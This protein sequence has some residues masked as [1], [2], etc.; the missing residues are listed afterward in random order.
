MEK[1]QLDSYDQIKNMLNTMRK[2]NT[3]NYSS[4]REQISTPQQTPTQQTQPTQQ[5]PSNQGGKS[6]VN[7]I[8]NVEVS[9]NSND[10]AD[11]T[12]NDDQKGNISQLIDDFRSEV[13]ELTDFGKLILYEQS[14]KLDGR[15]NDLNI[16][17]T[18][19]AGDDN[20][21]FLNSSSM[22]KLSDDVME[23]LTKLKTF[24]GKFSSVISN[25]ILTRK[26]N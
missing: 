19:S 18:L 3:S 17:F 24:E 5:T 14:A 26:D 21:V 16:N 12:L 8:N 11:L 22:L 2:F 25:I 20:G 15:I 23:M 13:S 9:L 1:K 10:Q 7:V 6:D 4:L